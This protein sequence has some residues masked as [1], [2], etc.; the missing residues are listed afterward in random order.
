MTTIRFD[1]AW[2]NSC[3]LG[4]ELCERGY[5]VTLVRD[6]VGRVSLIIAGGPHPPD[7][8]TLDSRLRAAAGKFAAQPAVR[9][10]EEL[11]SPESIIDSADIV[12]VR[13]TEAGGRLRI[14]DNRLVGADWTRTT[15]KTQPTK[16]VTL[17]G[18]KGGV[19]HS[20]ATFML[21]K[22]LANKG[23]CVLVVDLD[24]ESPGVGALAHHDN[25]LPD[26]GI[27]DHLVEAAVGNA[28]DLDLVSRS[29]QIRPD[30]NG[31][32]W[33]APAAGRPRVGYEYLAKLNRIYT[34]LPA[35]FGENPVRFGDRLDAA[36]TACEDQVEHRSRRPDV[37]L[38][39]SR[40]GIHDIAAVALTRLGELNFLFALD[41]SQTW[42][43]YRALFKQWQRL[44]DTRK[45]G[46]RLKMVASMTPAT[47]AD[48]YLSR[49]R[50]NAQ[51]CFSETLYE[52]ADPEDTD[53][54]NYGVGADEAP[55]APLPILFD[56]TLVALDLA[57]NP[58]WHARPLIQAAFGEFLKSA[59]MLIDEESI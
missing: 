59:A 21:A 2:R 58:D 34:D 25:D 22:H 46:E 50:D 55:H 5:D 40:A 32:V 24:L 3:D 53:A 54:F 41:N 47:D 37:V 45:I 14:L 11:F 44:P 12:I 36:V 51:S 20:T 33:V 27:V 18:F 57:D 9:M 43:G 7:R 39:D 29:R 13:E 8:A 16:R 49:F 17:Y 31:E 42:R 1:D 38:L 35:S 28:A 48:A 4:R 23:N 19:G 30:S 52:S 10:S 6:V 15:E 26:H 56:S